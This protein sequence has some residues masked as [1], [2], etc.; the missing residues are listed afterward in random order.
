MCGICGE[1]RVGAAADIG[2]VVRMGETMSDR[3]PDGEGVW[4]QGPVAL[5]HRRLNTSSRGEETE[6]R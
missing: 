3:G 1:L 2:A 6:K 5:S 4:A